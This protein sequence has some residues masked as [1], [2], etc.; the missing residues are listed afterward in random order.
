MLKVELTENYTGVKISGDYNDLDLL[1]DSIYYLIKEEPS[2]TSEY[3]M[4]NHIYGFLYDVRHAYQGDREAILIDNNYVDDRRDWYGFKK[5]DVTDK[6]MYFSFNYLLTDLFL[7]MVLIKYFIRKIDKKVNDVYNPYI[8]M[9]NYFYS[10]VLHSLENLLTE[11]KFNKVK[12]GLL[13]SIV[14]DSIFIPQWFEII[15]IDYAKMTKKQREKK[16]MHIM[17]AIYNYGDYEDYLK[18][19]IDIERLC[20]EKN[21]TLDNLHY[22]D[23]PEEIIW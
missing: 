5:K 8:N 19:K 2:S 17:D 14:T 10:L 13:E 21:C 7:D 22:D 6:N 3:T 12:K 23:Y 16:F 9:V 4:Q 20:K 1:Y 11:I 18:M 15:S